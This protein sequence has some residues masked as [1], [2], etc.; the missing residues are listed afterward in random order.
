[1]PKA[2]PLPGD[3]SNSPASSVGIECV[4]FEVVVSNKSERVVVKEA[5]KEAPASRF[6]L[7]SSPHV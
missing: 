3:V 4:I 7:V 6:H 5:D 1:M 2:L